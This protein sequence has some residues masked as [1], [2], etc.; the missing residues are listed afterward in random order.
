MLESL[1]C[2]TPV[3]A[4]DIGGIPDYVTSECGWLIPKGDI[5]ITVGLIEQICA[6]RD[7]ARSRREKARTR[8]LAFDWQRIAERVAVVYD[9]VRAGRSPSAAV[10]EFEKVVQA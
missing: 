1:A 7:I 3:I 6:N 10:T 2:G 8:A 4:T 9:A 5:E